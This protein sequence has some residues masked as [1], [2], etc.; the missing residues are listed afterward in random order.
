MSFQF[1][2][3]A[4]RRLRQFEEEKAQRALSDAQRIVEEQAAILK[5]QFAL[6]AEREEQFNQLSAE[7]DIRPQAAMFRRFIERLS[8]EITTQQ[9]RVLTAEKSCEEVRKQLL[10]AMKKRKTLDRLKEK[11]EQAFMAELNSEEEKFINEISINRF[12]L[13]NR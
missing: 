5:Q 3:E 11:G 2:L 12:M 8:N 7:G 1:K 9:A 13:K 10:V 6:R 4:V